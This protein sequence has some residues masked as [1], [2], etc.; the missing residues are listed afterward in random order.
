M[1]AGVVGV[2]TILMALEQVVTAEVVDAVGAVSAVV[3]GAV[4]WVWMLELTFA[5]FAI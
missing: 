2:A 5:V 3:A 4:V 1:G